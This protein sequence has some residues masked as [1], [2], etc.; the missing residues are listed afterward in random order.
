MAL[1]TATPD[2]RPSVRMVLLKSADERGFTFFTELRVAEGTRARREPARRAPLPSRRDP[3]AR[4]GAGRAPARAESDA[5]WATRPAASRRSAA[6]SNQSQPIGSREELEAAVAAQP[7]SRPVPDAGAAT[8]SS[9]TRMS[10]G[11]T[12]TT[13][14]TNVTFSGHAVTAGTSSCCNREAPRRRSGRCSP[15]LGGRRRLRS[16]DRRLPGV[17]GVERVEPARSTNCP[18]RRTPHA[19]RLDRLTPAC[20]PTSATA[21]TT[22]RS[23]ASRTSSCTAADA[24]VA[25]HV[26]VRG[27][28][29]QRPVPDP[30]ERA[31]RGRPCPRDQGD[32][33]VLIVDRDSLQALRALRAERTGAGWRPVGRDLEP[34]L[35]RAPAGDLDV[36]R[37]R[38]PADPARARALG[39]GGSPARSDHALRFTAAR[40]RRP[41]SARRATRRRLDRPVAA[42]DGPAL[43]LKAS[44]DISRS[45]AAPSCCRR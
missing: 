32:R 28:E 26:R 16:G 10:S 12:A 31:G 35:E 38:R 45:A 30:E 4:R 36:G 34:A 44:F 7:A 25:G 37:R 9:R 39:R 6:A 21:S 18:S 22:A 20:T 19:D 15:P 23:S 11:G 40:T 14:C 1:A 13:G 41:S 3:G 29:R 27:R 24:E 8:G 42:A 33:H 17:S 5:Y 2:G 43:R